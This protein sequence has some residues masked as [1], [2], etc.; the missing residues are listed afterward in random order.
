MNSRKMM[1]LLALAFVASL[2]VSAFAEDKKEWKKEH[3]RRAEVN[4]RLKN[5]NARVKEGVKDGKMTKAQAADIHKEDRQIRREERRDAAKHGGHITKA[6]Q[7]KLN[8]EENQVSKQLY[9]DKH[10]HPAAPTAPAAP[11]TPPANQ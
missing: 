8:K 10:A 6:E 2:S 4:K 5:Q 9:D 3:P 1:W 11:A 7:R